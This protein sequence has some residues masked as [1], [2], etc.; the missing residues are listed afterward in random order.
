MRPDT[1][2]TASADGGTRNRL[3]IRIIPMPIP[4]TEWLI[5][6]RFFSDLRDAGIPFGR[7]AGNDD[8]GTGLA[9]SKEQDAETNVRVDG[10]SMEFLGL[11][12]VFEILI[13]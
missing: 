4:V 8:R 11:P 9:P 2:S 12:S 7:G 13:N 10:F 6:H 5:K 3:S 1:I